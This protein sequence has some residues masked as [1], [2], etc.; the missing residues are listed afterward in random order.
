MKKHTIES[1]A[2]IKLAAADDAILDAAAALAAAEEAMLGAAAA[3]DDIGRDDAKLQVKEMRGAVKV[4]RGWELELRR[5][6]RKT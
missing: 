3:L 5:M 6:S 4:M 1:I 2:S